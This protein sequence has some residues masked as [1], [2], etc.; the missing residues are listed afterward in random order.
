MWKNA[1]RTQM[2]NA[3]LHKICDFYARHIRKKQFFRGNIC[4]LCDV[5]KKVE[6]REHVLLDIL[7]KNFAQ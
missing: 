5:V 3:N 6:R 2:F 4:I 7:Q 1:I